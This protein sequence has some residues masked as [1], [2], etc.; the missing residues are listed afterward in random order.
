MADTATEKNKKESA[1]DLIKE[2]L[3]AIVGIR[4]EEADELPLDAALDDKIGMDELDHVELTMWVEERV[5]YEF[6]I[7][8]DEAEKLKTLNDWVKL[9]EAKRK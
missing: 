1:L 9:I 5:N 7:A 6:E 8:D 3:I 2:G 4:K